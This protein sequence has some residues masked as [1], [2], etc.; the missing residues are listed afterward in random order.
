MY[1]KLI[2]LGVLKVIAEGVYPKLIPSNGVSCPIGIPKS[3]SSVGLNALSK[4]P[5][6][7]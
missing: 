1:K 3:I 6:Y 2:H 5:Y 4:S 7:F